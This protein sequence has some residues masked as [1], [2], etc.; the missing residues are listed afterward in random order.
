MFYTIIPHELLT[1]GLDAERRFITITRAGLLMQVEPV[2]A[3][4]ARLVR[5]H[6][7]DPQDYLN[8]N[9]QPGSVINLVAQDLDEQQ[10]E[11]RRW[12]DS[13]T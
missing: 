6:S 11:T 1:E 10:M 7:T 13:E 4:Y 2:E 9:W 5:V 8:P 12:E 3:P